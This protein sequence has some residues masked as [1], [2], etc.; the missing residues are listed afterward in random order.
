MSNKH[1]ISWEMLRELARECN[2]KGIPVVLFKRKRGVGM[3]TRTKRIYFVSPG[4]A[5]D[6]LVKLLKEKEAEK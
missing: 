6:H 3:Y 5:H 2:T 4:P 1:R